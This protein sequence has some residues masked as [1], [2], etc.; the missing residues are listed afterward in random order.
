MWNL[1]CHRDICLKTK[2]LII[3]CHV[4]PV[5]LCEHGGWTF[6]GNGNWDADRIRNEDLR[7]AGNIEE[8]SLF[9]P[10]RHKE[11]NRHVERMPNN[12]VTKME[13]L[14]VLTSGP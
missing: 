5:L 11:W 4:L 13:K 9:I 12:R 6:Q 14:E 1:L 3:R 7:N 8:V 2:S 10:T